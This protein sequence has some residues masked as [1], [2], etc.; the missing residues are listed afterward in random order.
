MSLRG[1]GRAAWV[2][3]KGALILPAY[4]FIPMAGASMWNLLLALLQYNWISRWSEVE[5][6][7]SNKSMSADAIRQ[8]Y[9][10]ITWNKPAYEISILPYDAQSPAHV[11]SVMPGLLIIGIALSLLSIGIL[12]VRARTRCGKISLRTV[13]DQ[14]GWFIDVADGLVECGIRVMAVLMLAMFIWAITSVALLFSP[15]EMEPL[16]LIIGVAFGL[17]PVIG[18]AVRELMPVLK[19]TIAY[20]Q[21]W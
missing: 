18:M 3:V 5:W 9:Q 13:C 10:N 19:R 15:P 20:L 21:D 16:V 4:L 8:V 17:P 11:L 1:V 14:S 6:A 12:F 2:F 7:I